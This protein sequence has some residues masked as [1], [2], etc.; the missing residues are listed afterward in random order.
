MAAE[1]SKHKWD[2]HDHQDADQDFVA[3][4][5]EF[6]YAGYAVGVSVVYI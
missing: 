1:Y 6:R 3:R 5:L 2:T 4:Y